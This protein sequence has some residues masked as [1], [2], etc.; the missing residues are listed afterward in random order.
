M[1][2]WS[3]AFED[4]EKTGEQE[5]VEEQDTRR[6]EKRAG[7]QHQHRQQGQR[8]NGRQK[9]DDSELDTVMENI[10]LKQ[11]KALDKHEQ[12][13]DAA[14]EHG[15]VCDEF[16]AQKSEFVSSTKLLLARLRA[17]GH[18]ATSTETMVHLRRRF[19]VECKRLETALPIYAR[20][21]DIVEAVRGNAVCVVLGETGSG[22]S[23]QLTQYIYEAGAAPGGKIVC[24]QPRKVAAISLATRVAQE[25]A[26]PLGGDLVGYRVGLQRRETNAT[27]L[28]Y[29]TDHVLLNDCLRDPLLTAYSCII[30]DEA[31]ERSIFTDLLLGMVK[32]CLAVRDD[33][34]VVITSATIDPELFVRYFGGCPVLK[35]HGRTYPVD[36]LYDRW[37]D[38]PG[39]GGDYLT[40]AVRTVK[41]IHAHE[42]P[43]D[44]LVFVPSALDTQK[45]CEATNQLRGVV[46]LPLHGGL[47]PNEQRNVFEPD[48]DRRR[49]IVFATNCAETSVTVPGIKYV[50]D[51]GLAK[52]R[53]YDPKLNVSSL[54][55][56]VISRSSADQRKGRAG[57]TAPGTCYRLYSE[58]CYDDMAP[59]STPEIL[60]VHIG[61]AMLKL[62]DIGVD[63]PASFDY[64]ESPPPAAM[65]AAAIALESLGATN[66]GRINELGRRLSRLNVQ[67]RL[68]K[69][70]IL[71]IEAGI[72]FDG[73]V[74][75]ALSTVGGYVFFRGVGNNEQETADKNKFRLCE[76][77]G[78]V[79]T[80]VSL[81]KQWTAQ[82]E[83]AKNRWCVDNSV[84]ARFMRFARDNI[85]E[86]KQTPRRDLNF[87]VNQDH[88]ATDVVDQRL[89]EILLQCYSDN[90]CFFS[91]HQRAGYWVAS[92]CGVGADEPTLHLHPSS[93][94]TSLRAQ[95][96]WIIFEHILVTS[97]PYMM[98]VTAINDDLV[99]RFV[100]DGRLPGVDV[101]SLTRQQLHAC[102]L[103]PV[104]PNVLRALTGRDFEQLKRLEKEARVRCK[105]EMLM[106]DASFNESRLVVCVMSDL[107][108]AATAVIAGK[109]SSEKDRLAAED[110]VEVLGGD[111]RGSGRGGGGGGDGGEVGGVVDGSS[112]RVRLVLGRGGAV[113]HLLMPEEFLTVVITDVA[114]GVDVIA[115]LRQIGHVLNYRR[116]MTGDRSRRWG[117]VTFALPEDALRA[118]NDHNV[119]F[120][121]RPVGVP[122][123]SKA[124]NAF[125]LNAKWCR[126][127]TR[128]YAFVVMEKRE[129]VSRVCGGI[130]LPRE[131]MIYGTVNRKDDMEVYLS[132][133]PLSDVEELDISTALK[134]K[135]GDDLS[136]TDVVIHRQ[137][138]DATSRKDLNHLKFLLSAEIKKCLPKKSYRIKMMAP[139]EKDFN[140]NARVVFTSAAHRNAAL[141]ELDGR[142]TIDRMPVTFMS[143]LCTSLIIAKPVYDINCQELDQLITTRS[144]YGTVITPSKKSSPNADL[145][146]IWIHSNDQ[147]GLQTAADAVRRVV[148]PKTVEFESTEEFRCV[149][150]PAGREELRRIEADTGAK[151]TVDAR[152][153]NV[154]VHGPETARRRAAMAVDRFVED[155]KTLLNKEKLLG[156]RG[157]S[158]RL[159]KLLLTKYG[160]DLEH[161]QRRTGALFLELQLR[162]H[163]LV[164]RGTED[165]YTSLQMALREDEAQLTDEPTATP[166]DDSPD[167]PVCFCPIDEGDIYRLEYC[168]HA[169]CRPCI[170]ALLQQKCRDADFPAACVQEDCRESVVLRDLTN[171]LGHSLEAKSCW[172]RA[173]LESLVKT[174]PG[175]YHYCTTPDCT[176]VYRAAT[177]RDDGVRF[178]CCQCS[179]VTCTACHV[180]YHDDYDTCAAY[181]ATHRDDKD[182]INAWISE[183]SANR[184]LCPSCKTPMEKAG[185]CNHMY[186]SACHAHMC[187]TC[188]K[189]FPSAPATYDHMRR[190]HGGIG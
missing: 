169:Y 161:L 132:N 149:T 155:N 159:V 129:D 118:V 22:K 55:L 96:R 6:G 89:A 163:A 115:E 70:I 181:Q 58:E 117:K 64:V 177:S 127:P 158:A 48:N 110:I 73:L 33:L 185:G 29:V 74:A 171:L 144:R 80:F 113:T 172:H 97:R 175:Q 26:T 19:G 147:I 47:P 137:N 3:G 54:T 100:A 34:R 140:F 165:A 135:A 176:T 112:G 61:Q 25:L 114:A 66:D 148:Q 75:T 72:G 38:K 92:R 49:K 82:P 153:M 142:I 108:D 15:D 79:L 107:E 1:A 167:C 103:Q 101:M 156:T 71:A 12:K 83:R 99:E 39:G 126:R 184:A 183:N 76:E 85:N 9:N 81:Y 170:G 57:R 44:I 95:P 91:G 86:L 17:V 40:L 21:T 139:G 13:R 152:L 157:N 98:N 87:F 84:N 50:V 143:D 77:S 141:R 145:V 116:F 69:V 179:A 104:G 90:L 120:A 133:V 150:G 27:A 11:Q 51:T 5:K 30:I 67:P 121:V 16:E 20:R 8:M 56:S 180:H 41:S 106:L 162:R 124:D 105:T 93:A 60:R 28:L 146:V 23:T 31:H 94:L 131:R 188:K 122:T 42:P 46:S 62:M 59:A 52:E 128:G 168:G 24:T 151:I 130:R 125:V 68:G 10:Q 109:I 111:G 182:D 187:W 186:C 189:T 4:P 35:V 53:T 154:L 173:A 7:H 136:I 45:G 174:N 166:S 18:D 123:Q 37:S 178:R 65:E 14:G 102:P 119:S 134:R 78:D 63:D 88:E 36:V 138:V 160:V 43:G 2:S 32:R 190:Y 164:F